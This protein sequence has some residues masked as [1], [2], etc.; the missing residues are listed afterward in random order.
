VDVVDFDALDG[1]EAV[2]EVLGVGVIV[3]EAVDVIAD[4]NLLFQ[5]IPSPPPRGPGKRGLI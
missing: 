1:G 4:R 3:G 5:P 2:S